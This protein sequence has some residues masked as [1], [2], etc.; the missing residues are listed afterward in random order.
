MHV[1]AIDGLPFPY[2]GLRID[3]KILL[4]GKLHTP[5]AAMMKCD[6]GWPN[7]QMVV[8]LFNTTARNV[9]CCGFMAKHGTETIGSANANTKS[10]PVLD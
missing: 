7:G 3:S 10:I 8:L 5:C 1:Q 2:P 9:R 4:S 6:D